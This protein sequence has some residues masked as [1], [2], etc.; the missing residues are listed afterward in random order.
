MLFLGAGASRGARNARGEEPPTGHELATRIRE[1]FLG[2]AFPEMPL[3]NLAEV[4]I[5]EAG[6]GNVQEFIAKELEGFEPAAH[7]RLLPRFVWYGLATTNYDL[8]LEEAYRPSDGRLQR[9]VSISTPGRPIDEV[10]RA[11]DQLVYLKLHGCLTLTDNPDFPLVLTPDHVIEHRAKRERL[12]RTLVEWG[13]N[14]TIVFAG[15][16]MQDTDLRA[17]LNELDDLK[18]YRP[19]YYLVAPDIQPALVRYWA[20]RRMTVLDGSFEDFLRGLDHCVPEAGRGLTTKIPRDHAISRRLTSKE[21]LGDAEQKALKSDLEYVHGALPSESGDPRQFYRGFDLGW[22]PIQ[23]GWDVRRRLVDTLLSEVILADEGDRRSSAELVAI[24]A[25]A[26]AGKSLL[27]RRLAWEAATDFDALVLRVRRHG[28]I[29]H[30]VVANI[31]RATASRIFLFVDNA[32]DRAE[33]LRQLVTVARRDKLPLTVV[34]TERV[35]EWNMGC[36]PLDG[37]VTAAYELRYLSRKEIEQLVAL[38]DTHDCLFH[39]K[40]ATLEERIDAFEKRAGRQLLVALHEATLGTPFEE[41]LVDEFNAIRPRRA[42]SLYLTV[43]VL[44]RLGVP[45]RAGLISRTHRIPFDEFKEKLLDPLEHVVRARMDERTGDYVYVARHPYIA[46]IVF[47][48]IL[49]DEQERF[50]EYAKLFRH[51]NL[52]YSSDSAAFRS[53]VRGRTLLELFPE[54]S[55]VEEL[56]DMAERLSPGDAN[57][58]HQ[59]ALYQMRRPN[60][61]LRVAHDLLKEAQTKRE[62]ATSIRHSQAELALIRAQR[63]ETAFEREKYRDECR[64]IAASLLDD[65]N[66]GR[67]ARHTLAK[68]LLDELK[69]AF[70]SGDQDG[71]EMDSLLREIESVIDHGLAE[72]PGDSYLASTEADFRQLLRDHEGGRAV[73]EE[74]F[75]HNRRDT[76]IAARLAKV[77][78]EAGDWEDAAEVLKSALEA[79]PADKRL[80]YLYAKLL[81]LQGHDDPD[82]QLYYLRRSF[83]EWDD[84]YDAQFWYARYAYESDDADMRTR[85]M[86][87]FAQLGEARVPFDERVRVRSHMVDGEQR[88]VFRG[89]VVKKEDSYAFVTADGRGEDLF[90]HPGESTPE[91]WDMLTRGDRCAFNIGFNFR[92]PVAVGVEPLG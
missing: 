7:H 61:N 68:V 10:A 42:Q 89:T 22:Y 18:D 23:Q 64:G 46:Q 47:E 80:N 50:N 17:V 79:T 16:G 85:A 63:A 25:E 12:Y 81:R 20:A 82:R 86:N 44:N 87:V 27:L 6:L 65:E 70:S 51:M 4:A 19:P 32:A 56:F 29:N 13:N 73:L 71:T 41:I 84:N 43:C 26:G 34:T 2:A 75:K 24:K 69:E 36:K 88:K 38:L 45:V 67:F 31:H 55:A 83:T 92:G 5:N 58:L 30:S 49:T 78:T 59:R 11:E 39:L 54:H 15:H 1:R 91:N 76:Y 74:A 35:N 3:A 57:I 9:L 66:A 14:H 53:M 8:I 28:R 48:R 62:R 37:L 33:E 60:G 72:D 77:M 90:T 40:T 52:S 21:D